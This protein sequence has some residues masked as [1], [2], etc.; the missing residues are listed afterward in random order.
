MLTFIIGTVACFIFPPMIFAII[1]FWF[2]GIL[3]GIIGLIIGLIILSCW[4]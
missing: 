1:G 2:C 4:D 3:G